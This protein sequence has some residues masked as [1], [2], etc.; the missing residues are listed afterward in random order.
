MKIMNIS[1][2]PENINLIQA[3]FGIYGTPAVTAFVGNLWATG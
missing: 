1:Q 3:A 2:P